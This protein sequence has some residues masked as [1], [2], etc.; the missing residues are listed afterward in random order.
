[1]KTF[2][3]LGSEGFLTEKQRKE[4]L[5]HGCRF[6]TFE[7]CL[8]LS[9]GVKVKTYGGASQISVEDYSQDLAA[10][11]CWWE[12]FVKKDLNGFSGFSHVKFKLVD[13]ELV[14]TNK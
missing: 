1:M 7:T 2:N 13:F 11:I 8:D 3:I 14:D 10:F 6:L 9:Q 4:P 12:Y 5:E